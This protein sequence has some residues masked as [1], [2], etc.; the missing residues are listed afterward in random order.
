[1]AIKYINQLDIAEK[2]VFIRLD[3]NVPMDEEGT[4]KDDT[5]IRAALPTI[6]YALEK[7]AK[8]ILGSHLGRPKGEKNPKYSLKPVAARLAE[9]LNTDIIFPED[10]IGDAVRKL[11]GDLRPGQIMLLENLR[12]HKEEEKNDPNFA[13][14][15]AG[16]CEVYIND[17][18]G[19]AHRAH[20]STAGMEKYVAEVGAG[21]LMKKEIEFLSRLLAKP[22]KPF[23]AIIGGAKVSDKLGVIENLIDKANAIL[24][25]GGMSYTFLK[26]KGAQIGNSLFEPDRVHTAKKILDRAA[27]R[28]VEILL[29]ADHV[30][31]KELKEGVASANTEDENIPQGMM[32]LDIGKKTISKYAEIISAASTTFWNGPMG[33]CEIEPF[34]QG[35]LALARAV[36]ES[37]SVSVVGGGDSIAA[38]NKAGLADRFSHVCT[39]GGASLE[40]L[41]GKKLPGIAALER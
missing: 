10:C 6:K 1:M 2:R 4:V 7:K 5:R 34:D 19:T 35:T 40:F 20:A 16:L 25:G 11:A 37:N 29:P 8:L 38:I 41:E 32:G 13:E 21:F 18:F 33:V 24:I 23:V 30:I 15:L 39:G 22:A 9:L 28:G 31:A 26:T 14:K 17:A 12:F 36:S 3:L 27:S